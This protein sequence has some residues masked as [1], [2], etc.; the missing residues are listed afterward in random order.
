MESNKPIMAQKFRGRTEAAVF[1][2]YQRENQHLKHPP[3]MFITSSKER[4]SH[5]GHRKT[6]EH[7]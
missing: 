1:R 3:H 6:E 2:G 4:R 7:K 5:K